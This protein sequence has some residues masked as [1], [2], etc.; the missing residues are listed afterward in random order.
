MSL[1]TK[2]GSMRHIIILCLLL[3]ACVNAAPKAS[4][5]ENQA[6]V[7]SE[8]TTLA[9]NIKA[10]V[11]IYF[12]YSVLGGITDNEIDAGVGVVIDSQ[13]VLVR[14]PQFIGE[15]WDGVKVLWVRIGLPGTT[16]ATAPWHAKIFASTKFMTLLQTDEVIPLPAVVLSRNRPKEDE[17]LYAVSVN[18]NYNYNIDQYQTSSFAYITQAMALSSSPKSRAFYGDQPISPEYDLPVG[19]DDVVN[20]GPVD[21]ATG[22]AGIFN[23]ENQ[24]VGLGAT[25]ADV[26]TF[27]SEAQRHFFKDYSMRGDYVPT[28][29]LSVLPFFREAGIDYRHAE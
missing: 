1:T 10:T 25:H 9:D 28:C 13:H 11:V 14:S 23:A 15:A 17:V 2:E 29:K 3:C 22:N 26:F 24:M 12:S 18:T 6:K 16:Y 20:A 19:F 4:V 21:G 8:R 7:I 27:T 5:I